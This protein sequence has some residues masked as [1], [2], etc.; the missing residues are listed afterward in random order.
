MNDYYSEFPKPQVDQRV[1]SLVSMVPPYVRME[2]P[3]KVIEAE[4]LQ[5]TQELGK[6]YSFTGWSTFGRHEEFQHLSRRLENLI[7]K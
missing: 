6:D 1:Q 5:V 4:A 2:V 3:L 7:L